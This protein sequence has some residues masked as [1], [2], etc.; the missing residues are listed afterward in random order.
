MCASLWLSGLGLPKCVSDSAQLVIRELGEHSRMEVF[1]EIF[2]VSLF[3]LSLSLSP[4]LSLAPSLRQ[5]S[6]G[7]RLMAEER[8]TGHPVLGSSERSPACEVCFR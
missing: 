8:I 7:L 1:Q 3:V 2:Q 6:C 4:S 5:V